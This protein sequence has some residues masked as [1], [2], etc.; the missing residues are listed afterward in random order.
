MMTQI[1][2]R[3]RWNVLIF[4]RKTNNWSDDFCHDYLL[5]ADATWSR[6]IFTYSESIRL[7][8]FSDVDFESSVL[9]YWSIE[10][11]F[12]DFIDSWDRRE[13]QNARKWDS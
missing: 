11:I 5:Y 2:I 8:L 6:F 1:D 9:W 12:F 7:V 4:S 13:D 3:T 10:M